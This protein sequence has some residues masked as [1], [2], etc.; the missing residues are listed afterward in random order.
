MIQP[1]INDPKKDRYSLY[2]SKY[3]IFT[4]SEDVPGEFYKIRT[5]VPDGDTWQEGDP[6]LVEEVLTFDRFE[7][8]E[9]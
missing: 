7:P 3:Y 1:Y 5:V 9:K 2:A 6:L 4:L 8:L